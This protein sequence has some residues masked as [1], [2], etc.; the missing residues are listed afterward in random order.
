LLTVT[1]TAATALRTAFERADVPPSSGI[2]IRGSDPSSNS[3]D[4]PTLHLEI[5]PE[6]QPGD[7]QVVAA[8]APPVFIDA[9]VVPM[10]EDKV[11]DGDIDADGRAVFK[12]V[13]SKAL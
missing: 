6:K 8:G 5:V 9:L 10:I 4:R 12:I 2:R 7:E 13:P 3:N 1:D 11:L